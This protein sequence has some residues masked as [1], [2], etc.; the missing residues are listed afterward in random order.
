MRDPELNDDAFDN[1]SM[2]GGSLF[3]YIEI[4]RRRWIVV[5]TALVVVT[6]AGVIFTKNQ[7]K[8]FVSSASLA[9]STSTS[10]HGA[11][12]GAAGSSD[13]LS[14]IELLTGN[15][16][17][18]ETQAAILSSPDTLKKAFTR[19]D[20]QPASQDEPSKPGGPTSKTKASDQPKSSVN[21]KKTDESRKS[22]DATQPEAIDE[23]PPI[24]SLN[25]QERLEGFG[26]TKDSPKQVPKWA[27]DIEQKKN[28]DVIT[29]NVT[30]YK[31]KV[32]AKLANLIVQT[33]LDNDLLRNQQQAQK[34]A[35]FVQGE[36]TK[37][38]GQL[39]DASSDLA[40][41]AKKTGIV[42]P[43][44]QLTGATK[45]LIEAQAELDKTRVAA[46]A[47]KLEVDTLAEQVRKLSPEIDIAHI[48]QTN[49]DYE[50]V[51]ARISAIE[52]QIAT[53]KQAFTADSPEM[54]ALN[55][56]LD[57]EKRNLARFSKDHI[58]SRTIARNP[59]LDKVIDLY[60][61][62]SGQQV[63]DEAK[64]NGIQAYVDR[65]RDEFKAI[66]EKGRR[67][68]ELKEEVEKLLKT[69]DLLSARYYELLIEEK[70]S[71]PSGFFVSYAT[72][73]LKPSFPNM[74]MAAALSLLLGILAG[75]IAA[76]ILERL[77]TRIHDPALVERITGLTVLTAVPEV[78]PTAESGG[79]SLTIGSSDA[80]SGFAESFRLLRNNIAFSV[81]DTQLKIIAVTSAGKGDGKST[82]SVNLAIAMAMDGNRVLLIDA[83]LRRPA[84]HKYLSLSREV[85]FTNVVRGNVTL[86]DAVLPTAFDNVSCLP[87]GPLPPSPSE[88][89]NSTQARALFERAVELYDFVLVD[90]PPCTGLSDIQVISTV[91]QG[92]VLVV[93]LD[94]TEKQ[95]LAGAIRLLNLA[96][97]PVLGMVL[98]RVRYSRSNYYYYSYYYYYGYYGEDEV[99]E[100]KR[101]R[102]GPPKDR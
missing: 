78:K 36:M 95:Y 26:V 28:V 81:P 12:G 48:I 62:A 50:Q 102:G 8:M 44:I 93:A 94:V 52:G 87:T 75:V 53:M 23:H 18:V 46:R 77:D 71:I 55:K 37:V 98:N 59:A 84:L 56:A 99:D 27:F 101:K 74:M 54:V 32:A 24:I 13:L 2:R 89:L 47:E 25:D 83:D 80:P 22:E 33:Y 15:S 35:D 69:Y 67:Y 11:G 42:D 1:E 43:V 49:P 86:E 96:G 31:P 64:Q 17:N 65:R 40:A 29:V 7:R 85:G 19:I 63:V 41:Y 45:D 66:P 16:H 100:K 76:M 91:V 70:S 79:R 14:N 5:L 20:L 72:E 88:F 39:Q 58:Y 21:G 30:S 34:G 73:P 57:A 4:L 38:K 61:Q 6:I 3:E 92:I 51:R 60:A 82:T 97:A 68:A 9:V 90:C 10:P